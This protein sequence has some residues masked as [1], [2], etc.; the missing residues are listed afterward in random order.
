MKESRTGHLTL[1]ERQALYQ[2]HSEG[3]RFASIARIIGCHRKT[4]GAELKRNRGP[5]YFR[6][7]ESPLERARSAHERAVRRRKE[8]KEGKRGPLKLAA[9][10]LRIESLLEDCKYSP[11]DI[12][13]L[14]RQGDDPVR[15]SGK[16]IRR[17]ILAEA[18]ELQQ[19]LPFRGR[20]RR[21][22]LT[23]RKGQRRPAPALPKQSIHQR[24]AEARERLVAGHK[25][26]DFLVCKQSRVSILVG[27]DRKCRRVWLRRVENRE[28]DTTRAALIGIEANLCPPLRQTLTLD[29]DTGFQKVHDLRGLLA[30]ESFFCDPYCAWQK[31]SVEN[32]N[33]R[34]RR[35]IPKGTDLSSVSQQTLNRI[36]E[37]LNARPFECLGDL[38]PD[39]VWEQEV[40]RA[41]SM[42]H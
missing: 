3:H 8:S 21:S 17:W 35:F 2:M 1:S 9:I 32:V 22:H 36:E 18:K 23:P 40:R 39:Q 41:R 26:F 6:G 14:L 13:K 11:E 4:V 25:E 24:P 19:H 7:K 42:L 37:I 34:V 33:M 27:V 28:A 16:T 10:R 29:N 12:T 15:V 38:S 30:I 5:V 20:K 31:G